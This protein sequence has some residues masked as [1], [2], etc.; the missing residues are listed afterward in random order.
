MIQP[1]PVMVGRIADLP[2]TIVLPRTRPTNSV[3]I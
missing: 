3:P 1:F 2:L